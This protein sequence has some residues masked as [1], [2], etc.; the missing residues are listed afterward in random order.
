M[1]G[2]VQVGDNEFEER[3]PA[4]INVAGDQDDFFAPTYATMFDLGAG[5]ARICATGAR[6][7]VAPPAQLAGQQ[8][9][10]SHHRTHPL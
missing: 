5:V 7:M 6:R 4:W 8:S 1:T 3:S 9:A 10:Q 2:Y